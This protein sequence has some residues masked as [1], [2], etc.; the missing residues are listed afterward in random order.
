[1]NRVEIK[2]KARKLISN[3]LWNLWKP[4]LII[5]AINIVLSLVLSA[6][7]PA[8]EYY[9]Y[10]NGTFTSYYN[11]ADGIGSILLA[12]LYVGYIVYLLKFI[13]GKK[14]EVKDVFSKMNYVL[15][16]WAA[17]FLASLF[18]GIGLIFLVVP[19]I[20]LALMFA[21]IQYIMADRAEMKMADTMG[22]L[23]QSKEM[24]DGHKWDFFVFGLSFIGW[25]LL[26]LIT[27]GIAIIYVGPYIAVAN[28]LY[29]EELKKLKK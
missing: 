19:G 14:F 12:P 8:K 21:M 17:S 2:E 1:M 22:I 6:I 29:Y 20:I 9:D 4:L 24:M 10:V 27:F 13:R 11:I 15:P 3:N 18:S 16:I 5:I 7:F 28:G 26:V 25:G 23:K